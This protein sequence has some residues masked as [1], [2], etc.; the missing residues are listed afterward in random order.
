MAPADT[1]AGG[2]DVA[3]ADTAAAAA[4][5]GA[6]GSHAAWRAHFATLWAAVHRE[7]TP[8]VAMAELNRRMAR[9]RSMQAEALAAC[10][11]R[12]ARP[13][14]RAAAGEAEGGEA[15][16]VEAEGVTARALR[17]GTRLVKLVPLQMIV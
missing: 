17:P 5:A 15:E 11:A 12:L 13:L 3:P 6:D 7:A 4:A 1:A 14:A 10:E 2:A 8:A 16:G 9:H